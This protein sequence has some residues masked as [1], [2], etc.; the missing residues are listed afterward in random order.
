MA[1]K[2]PARG[3][4]LALRFSGS[5][6][7][8]VALLGISRISVPIVLV[9]F[10]AR[11]NS[12]DAL[13]HATERV[14][15]NA[16]Y[17]RRLALSVGASSDK[18][19]A[20]RYLERAAALNPFDSQVW[21]ELGLSAETSGDLPLAERDLL[22]AVHVDRRFS[23]QWE[24]EQFYYRHGDSQRF[25]QW[26]QRAAQIADD[27]DLDELFRYCWDATLT[28][29]RGRIMIFE[30]IAPHRPAAIR[31][32]SFLLAENHLADATPVGESLLSD[33]EPREKKLLLGFCERLVDAGQSE[34]AVTIWNGL[35]A[36]RLIPGDALSPDHGV[37]LTNRA[38]HYPFLGEGFDWRPTTAPGIVWEHPQESPG[39]LIS[40]SGEQPATVEVLSQFI[41]VLPSRRYRFN[42]DYKTAGFAV[43]TV[44]RWHVLDA[45]SGIELAVESPSLESNDW[46]TGTI[47]FQT[48]E[49]CHMVRLLLTY[50]R[51]FATTQIAGSLALKDAG[52]QFEEG[53]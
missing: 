32:L 17:W 38:F 14:P 25:W 20:K 18:N 12:V 53:L 29:S 43:K 34:A 10:A 28:E 3:I 48:S 2:T 45:R 27:S 1:M 13:K 30:R 52:L 21:I 26:T 35:I 39:I 6:V 33:A 41:P 40:L 44:L 19:E 22:S 42:F 37:L 23:P 50:R 16:D 24:L 51:E 5:L 7:A 49:H 15:D 31:Y 36:R 9:D 4:A 46:S 11:T 47:R 8:I